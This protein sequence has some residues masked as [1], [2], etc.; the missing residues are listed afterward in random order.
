MPAVNET[1][2]VTDMLWKAYEVVCN[3]NDII[4]KNDVMVGM[5]IYFSLST[6]MTSSP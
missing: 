6:L 5:S 2:L 4:Q 1:K 3:G